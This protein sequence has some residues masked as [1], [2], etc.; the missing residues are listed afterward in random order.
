MDYVIS[1]QMNTYPHWMDNANR[2]ID[3][4]WGIILYIV[5]IGLAIFFYLRIDLSTVKS[6]LSNILTTNSSTIEYSSLPKSG[7]DKVKDNGPKWIFGVTGACLLVAF[8]F[9]AYRYIIYNYYLSEI[10]LT[11]GAR[12]AKNRYLYDK[13]EITVS[14]NKPGGLEFAYG[15]WLKIEDWYYNRLN[16]KYILLK[17]NL[18]QSNRITSFAPSMYLTSNNTLRVETQTYSNIQSEYVELQDIPLKRWFHLMVAVQGKNL[19]IYINGVLAKRKTLDG[20]PRQNKGKV[21][22]TPSINDNGNVTEPGFGGMTYNVIYYRYYPNQSQILRI[23]QNPP[24]D[25]VQPCDN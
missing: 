23:V 9:Y 14:E 7:F 10:P 6:S 19:D 1:T 17:G 22:I 3:S 21:F 16:K 4:N 15:M 11:Q 25:S 20:L 2:F 18:D 24:S 8:G 12:S 5:A 13:S